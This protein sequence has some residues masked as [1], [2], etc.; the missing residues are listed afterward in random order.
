M[1]NVLT[2]VHPSALEFHNLGGRVIGETAVPGPEVQV[3]QQVPANGLYYRRSGRLLTP[4][5]SGGFVERARAGYNQGA[6]FEL[7]RTGAVLR[8]APDIETRRRINPVHVIDGSLRPSFVAIRWVDEEGVHQAI[9]Q[10]EESSPLSVTVQSWL[11][12]RVMQ[13]AFSSDPSGSVDRRVK[14]AEPE[15]PALSLYQAALRAYEII[16]G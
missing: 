8:Q 6:W 9:P 1:T 10:N 15:D 4:Q 2:A 14:S 3:Y 12:D 16:R 11:G 13:Q 7:Q 5:A